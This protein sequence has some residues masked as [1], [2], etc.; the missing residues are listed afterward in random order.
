MRFAVTIS[1]IMAISISAH[2][3]ETIL[4]GYDPSGCIMWGM[5]ATDFKYSNLI[6]KNN[7]LRSS[8]EADLKAAT[9]RHIVPE[10]FD[11]QSFGKK[12]SRKKGAIGA[13]APTLDLY[14]IYDGLLEMKCTIDTG[15]GL[16]S[17]KFDSQLPGF[18]F[19]CSGSPFA[20][21]VPRIVDTPYED[22]PSNI[23]YRRALAE[24]RKQC[25]VP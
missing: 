1:I 11:G 21:P 18:N 23:L 19:R 2:G 10:F 7:S 24:Y 17:Y 4:E 5:T 25:S 12:F 13:E 14:C 22:G 6:K 20:C 15:N 3:T 16:T 9:A 8:A